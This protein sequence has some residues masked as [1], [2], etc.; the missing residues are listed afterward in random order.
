[1]VRVNAQRRT[2]GGATLACDTI[3]RAYISGSDH[4]MDRGMEEKIAKW[5]AFKATCSICWFS[6]I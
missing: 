5:S 2:T 3:E 4:L 6:V 1:M